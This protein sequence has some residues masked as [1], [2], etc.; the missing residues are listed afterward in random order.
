MLK[1]DYLKNIFKK[2]TLNS[3]CLKTR[4]DHKTLLT[5]NVFEC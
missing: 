3:V 2:K 5:T 1:Q 4:K